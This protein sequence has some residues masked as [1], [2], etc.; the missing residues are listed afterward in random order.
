MIIPKLLVDDMDRSVRFYRDGLGFKVTIAV[1]AEG[2]FHDDGRTDGAEFVQ[3]NWREAQLMLQ[4]R[5]SAAAELPQVDWNTKPATQVYLR[6]FPASD[7]DLD[8][9]SAA[10]LKG[11]EMTWYGMEEVF[12]RDPDGHVLCLGAPKGAAPA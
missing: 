3:L 6:D 1:M 8:A 2:E 7:I 4:T 12:L 10:I 5:S 11:P 9:L